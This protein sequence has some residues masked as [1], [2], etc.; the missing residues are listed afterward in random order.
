MSP[1]RR[2]RRSDNPPG[3]AASHSNA[4]TAA[5]AEPAKTI[6]RPSSRISSIDL[7]LPNIPGTPPHTTKEVGAAL[8]RK[9][10]QRKWPYFLLSR[11][12]PAAE[13]SCSGK[14]VVSAGLCAYHSVGR[15]PLLS[16]AIDG[17]RRARHMPPK[18]FSRFLVSGIL[19]FSAVLLA[20]FSRAAKPP[21]YSDLTVH[22]WGTFTSI[23]G[24]DGQA[25][26]WL[27]LSGPSD[28]PSF[29]EHF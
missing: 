23:A 4:P 12:G 3:R 6:I 8:Y 15:V 2:P 19:I 10:A 14:L 7:I 17:T 1:G 28:L 11:K 26:R 24:N 9:I 27:P 22:E 29:V 18:R 5:S 20:H 13:D 25:V 16:P 21:V